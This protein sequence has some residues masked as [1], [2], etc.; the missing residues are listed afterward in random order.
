MNEIDLHYLIDLEGELGPEQKYVP[1]PIT[2]SSLETSRFVLVPNDMFETNQRVLQTHT[3]PLNV[4]GLDAENNLL[5]LIDVRHPDDDST[6]AFYKSA[7][8][9]FREGYFS[10]LYFQADAE[11]VF[12]VIHEERGYLYRDEPDQIQSITR[13]LPFRVADHELAYNV[14]SAE[15][16][17]VTYD[18]QDPTMFTI[19]VPYNWSGDKR[20]AKLFQN[21]LAPGCRVALIMLHANGTRPEESFEQLLVINSDG[22]YESTTL[23][24]LGEVLLTSPWNPTAS[25]LVEA[26]E[27]ITQLRGDS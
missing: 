9:P 5:T 16:V 12:A 18:P 17:R 8:I 20:L 26:D 11:R 13:S 7:S 21:L 19:A 27:K 24:R 15:G 10:A 6:L 3:E 4:W 2:A 14:L 22:Q 23:E 1:D 25:E